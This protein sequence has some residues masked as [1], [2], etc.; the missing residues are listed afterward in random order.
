M[1]KKI[2]Y[3]VSN[4]I[5]RVAMSIVDDRGYNQGFKPSASVR[6]RTQRRVDHLYDSIQ[7]TTGSHQLLEIGCG[8]GEYANLLAQNKAIQVT[9]ADIC[10]PFIREAQQRYQL[11][12]LHFACVDFTDTGAI[13]SLFGEQAFDSVV[14]NGILHHMYYHIDAVLQKIHA[15]LKPGGVLAFIEPNIHNPYIACIFSIPFA[16]RYARLE[17]AEMAFSAS[18]ITERLVAAGFVGV[19]VEYY[20]FLVPGT[21]PAMIE[22]VIAFGTWAERVPGIKMLAQSL[23]IR[24][25]K[26]ARGTAEEAHVT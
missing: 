22:S 1:F 12:N 6:I 14:G 3:D 11:P 17:P 19:S 26:P 2:C 16:R 10:L 15:I 20:D 23:S 8:T 7:P 24:A 13:T 4:N 18:F 21:P 9:A 25:Y 5:E